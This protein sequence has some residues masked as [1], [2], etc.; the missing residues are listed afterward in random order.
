MKEILVFEVT[1]ASLSKSTGKSSVC[2]HNLA[3][4]VLG[5]KPCAVLIFGALRG[6]IFPRGSWGSSSPNSLIECTES[7]ELAL[8]FKEFPS[9]LQ[10]GVFALFI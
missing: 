8:P 6:S 4:G 10:D 3:V 1:F 7:S 2:L 9:I 5:C